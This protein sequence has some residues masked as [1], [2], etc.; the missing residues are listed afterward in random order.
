MFKAFKLKKLILL[1]PLQ[2]KRIRGAPAELARVPK[3]CT[4]IMCS[5][6]RFTKYEKKILSNASYVDEDCL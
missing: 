2:N 1:P 3:S 5:D 4:I 6:D